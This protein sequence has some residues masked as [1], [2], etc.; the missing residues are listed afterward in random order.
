MATSHIEC[1]HSPQWRSA[2]AAWASCTPDW[3]N[4]QTQ[5]RN[6]RDMQATRIGSATVT[7]GCNG[8]Y[9]L[10]CPD[11]KPDCIRLSDVVSDRRYVVGRLTKYFSHR[12]VFATSKMVYPRWHDVLLSARDSV[13][14]FPSTCVNLRASNVMPKCTRPC[15]V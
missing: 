10:P 6:L 15:D 12:K 7:I 9:Q 14:Q 8:H 5:E 1:H 3:W 13:R 2:P 4:D 11:C